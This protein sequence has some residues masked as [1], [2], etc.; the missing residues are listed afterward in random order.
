MRLEPPSWWYRGSIPL[1]AWSLLPASALYGGIVR[2]RF[3][4]ASP[5]RSKLPVICVGNF[6]L[7][8]A[9]KTPAAIKLASLLR[10]RG[11][12]PA[13]LTRGYGGAKPGPYQVSPT[14]DDAETV[15]DEALLLAEAGITV[16]SRHRPAGALLLENLEADTI[17]MDDGFQN[18]SL[19]KNFNLIVVHAGPSIGCGHVFP[20]GP[21]RA[22][23]GFQMAMADAILLMGAKN[24]GH[25]AQAISQLR[26][27]RTVQRCRVPNIFEARIVALPADE[28]RAKSFLAF[29]AIGRPQKFFDTLSETGIRVSNTRSFRDHHPFSDDDA[30][31]LIAE[32]QALNAGLITTE[33]DHVRLKGLSGARGELYR[34]ALPLPITIEFAQGHEETLMSAIL[35]RI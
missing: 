5:Y 2:L 30:K 11:R 24:S 27:A 28:M 17:V 22:P 20:L 13:F 8:G 33:K 3:H 18:P 12:K 21:L 4:M 35:A 16:V 32:A 25:T 14:R 15:G 26:L 7:G 19:A 10:D 9:G 29:C 1:G 31:A 34:L 6:T 23:L